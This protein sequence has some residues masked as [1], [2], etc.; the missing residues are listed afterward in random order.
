M[1]FGLMFFAASEEAPAPRTPNGAPNGA[2][3]M[4]PD[5]AIEDRYRLVVEAARFAD[6][7]GFESV[8]VPER[9][10]TQ[11]GGL[12]PNPA[13]LHAALARETRRVALRAG[14]VVLPLHDPIRVVEEWSMVDN[15]SRG[16]VG[17]SFA[18]GWNPADF[19]F[20][21][22]RYD[23]RREDLAAGIETVRR[24]WRGEPHSITRGD[25]VAATVQ[26]LPTPVQPELPIW[27][28]AAGNPETYT[29]AGEMGA[30]LLTHL[31]DQGVDELA[32]KIARY[33][34]AR[35]RAGHEPA[36]GTV[37]LMLHTFLGE[38]VDA[39]RAE[40]REPYCRYLESNLGLLQGLA[41]SRGT[42]V[43]VQALSPDDRRAFVG[44]L[45]DRF[46]SA[47]G[48]IG[49]PAS[50]QPLVA[51]L[52]RA[53][54]DE[55]A[56]LLDFGPSADAVLDRLP[57]LERLARQCHDLRPPPMS[58]DPAVPRPVTPA[59]ASEQLRPRQHESQSA[60][61]RH[62]DDTLPDLDTIRQRCPT[63][64][65]PDALYDRL[66]RHG[67]RMAGVFRR[68]DALWQGHGE[69]LA[70]LA[71][72]VMPAAV[73]APPAE[74]S[75]EVSAPDAVLLDA[76]L[77]A[78]I[79]ALPTDAEK[80]SRETLYLPSGARQIEV[81]GEDAWSTMRWSHAVITSAPDGVAVQGDITVRDRQGAQVARVWGLRLSPV[82]GGSDA[83]EDPV[84]ADTDRALVAMRWQ[85]LPS[86][87]AEPDS[88]SSVP[89]PLRLEGDWLLFADRAGVA[90]ALA[91]RL[92][93][94]GGRAETIRVASTGVG[95][96]SFG[97]AAG[98]VDPLDGDAVAEIVEGWR[99]T[100][101]RPR[102]VVHLASLDT[103]RADDPD[104][105][106]LRHGLAISL[107]TGLHLVRALDPPH[108]AGSRHAP[109][110]HV[111]TPRLWCVTRGAQAVDASVAGAEG[112]RV[113]A[114]GLAQAP[115]WGLARVAMLEHPGLAVRLVDLDPMAAGEDAAACL[116][117]E[118][119]SASAAEPLP[120]ALSAVGEPATA[121][122][123][124]GVD[125][126]DDE[127]LV[128]YRAGIRHGGRLERLDAAPNTVARSSG[129]FSTSGLVL[130]T[131]GL[132]GLG[133]QLA[134][135]LIDQGCRYL[136]L[137][138]R[139]PP[140]AE[141]AQC[142]QDLRKL[143][144]TVD[145]REV[146]V[147][148]VDLLARLLAEID[149][150][151][152]SLAATPLSAVFHLAGVPDAHLLRT[153]TWEQLGAVRAAKV[154]GAWN[155]HQ[156]TR[157]R[158]LD[159]F[160]L[161]SSAAAMLP[162]SHQ[163]AYAAASTF[164]DLLAHHRHARGL[165]AL[166][167]NWGPWSG[168]GHASWQTLQGAY[169]R[170]AALGVGSLAPTEA[171]DILGRLLAARVHSRD[172]GPQVGVI[173][174]D[175]PR[176]LAQ[177]PQL[178][179]MPLLASMAQHARVAHGATAGAAGAASEDSFAGQPAP[180]V[181]ALREA[182][183]EDRSDLLRD[184]LRAEVATILRLPGPD[185]VDPHRGFFD[186]GMDSLMAIELRAHL[187]RALG[188][189]LPAT[190]AFEHPTIHALAHHLA[191]VYLSRDPGAAVSA[192]GRLGADHEER[193]DSSQDDHDREGVDDAVDAV[194]GMDEATLLAMIDGELETFAE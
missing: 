46:A 12:Y 37:S 33:R 62:A 161:F 166:S 174:V 122:A 89:D 127:S 129:S 25:G 173:P 125:R 158:A 101:P 24:L 147:A 151:S 86:L 146:D 172:L 52:A 183:A 179:A 91:A 16:R 53:G 47:R 155:L 63:R 123:S 28:T 60:G 83:V 65:H 104:T 145:T 42:E 159:H 80:P 143:G 8:W 154:E 118:L 85:A 181:V 72:A 138:G 164:L 148:R 134:R 51:D 141:T 189:A 34:E 96:A 50:C 184:R 194:R 192:V 169:R 140:D 67:A 88:A 69:A 90:T 44:L 170:F 186:A 59:I 190:L 15:L 13:V 139:R 102:G 177:E 182:A 112:D 111:E 22:E 21:P 7:H 150:A 48:L 180:W 75:S 1:R 160:V 6:R 5:G 107:A 29:L 185:A 11:F 14:S 114:D 152:S 54:V 149:D 40:V 36:A 58:A 17:V 27:V 156:L 39:V 66:A 31:L 109:R 26:V 64:M 84:A 133:L 168:E 49:T 121:D 32:A 61:S 144:A 78:M 131:G 94:A 92:R 176:L 56:C 19:A 68:V 153:L 132:G 23:R 20:F 136:L 93:S 3:G 2:T 137:V 38:D 30:N 157:G 142:L 178:A 35:A 74:P 43:D 70:R 106:D 108:D 119:A 124:A 167:V 82:S 126:G 117:L 9:H 113:A 18:S 110:P 115:L 171:F 103:A 71:P 45:Y 187:Q 128:A 130:I 81:V 87:D 4:A 175:W 99:R 95:A 76:C 188:C 100:A 77:Q 97:S 41:R 10:F 162:L 98:A 57:V 191:S 135:W 105:E 193:H 116:A 163:G 73:T 120:A 165:P 55:I 79:A